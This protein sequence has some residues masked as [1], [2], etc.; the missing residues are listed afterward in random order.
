MATFPKRRNLH[1]GLLL[2]ES[3]SSCFMSAWRP[4]SALRKLCSNLLRNADSLLE[5]LEAVAPTARLELEDDR[6]DTSR[7]PTDDIFD[8][9]AMSAAGSR[10]TEAGARCNV[11]GRAC[12]DSLGSSIPSDEACAAGRLIAESLTPKRLS[13]GLVSGVPEHSLLTSLIAC[14]RRETVLDTLAVPDGTIRMFRRSPRKSR[15]WISA[16][17]RRRGDMLRGDAG[18]TPPPDTRGDTGGNGKMRDAPRS[19]VRAVI[20]TLQGLFA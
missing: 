4:A 6:R 5:A 12:D 1:Q 13:R 2:E 7:S 8:G 16:F 11:P 9:G 15:R 3:L 14:I 19:F 10:D 18:R 17:A 20:P